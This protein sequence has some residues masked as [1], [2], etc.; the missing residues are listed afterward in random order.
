[1]ST[2]VIT[3]KLPKTTEFDDVF[4][5]KFL[6]NTQ[7]QKLFCHP[8]IADWLQNLRNSTASVMV[9]LK[10]P[11][12]KDEEWRFTDLIELLQQDFKPA[13]GKSTSDVTR[14]ILPET[15][16]SCLVFVN[17]VYRHDFSNISGLPQGVY[18]GNLAELPKA[19]QEKIAN[20]FTEEQKEVFTALNTASI[21]DMSVVWVD[22]NVR[23]ENPIQ[24][25]N[26]S[27]GEEVPSFAQPRTLIVAE[28]GSSLHLVEYFVSEECG[29]GK[30]NF[31]FTNTVTEIWLA[32]N[33]QLIHNRIQQEANNTFHIGK[34]KV[35]QA[36]NSRY[37]GN[38]ISLGAKLYRHNLEI[39]Q[40]GEQTETNL[41][42]LT[43]IKGEQLA[44]THS[45]VLLNKPHG[46]V[47]QIHKCIID[48]KARAVFNGK[49][50]VPQ[51]AQMT[52][53]T[54]VNRNLMLSPK[55]RVNTKPELQ[56]TAD[57][58][59]CSHGATISQ[60]EA[61]EIFYLRSRGLTEENARNLLIDA[62]AADIIER[63]QIESLRHRLTQ[64]FSCLI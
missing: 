27:V 46:N 28:T 22:S 31:Y 47:N 8:E 58:V 23:V 49:I 41:N 59:K 20:Y 10:M 33:A 57:N 42:G 45:Q 19:K 60:L 18:V 21:T 11:S 16:H 64:C 55:A 43:M 39:N 7:E 1:M 12:T 52:N 48:D 50:F 9:E 15:A 56:I 24:L 6:K 40:T 14:F 32:E 34:S 4:L 25:I 53:A 35:T 63:I 30:G 61:D 44:D 62:F 38:E 37:I 29:E 51:T 54:Q 36:R 17:G 3:L 13:N 26:I 5:G 2:S